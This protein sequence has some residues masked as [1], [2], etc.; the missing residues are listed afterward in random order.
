MKHFRAI[1]EA[2]N[3]CNLRTSGNVD[4]EMLPMNFSKKMLQRS[5]IQ[6]SLEKHVTFFRE[7]YRIFRSFQNFTNFLII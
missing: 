7:A 1:H 5:G 6:F 3:L 4:Q 2:D